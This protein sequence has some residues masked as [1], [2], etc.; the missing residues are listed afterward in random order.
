MTV[1]IDENRLDLVTT[2]LNQALETLR[3][4]AK[5]LLP[6]EFEPT[7]YLAKIKDAGRVARSE[8]I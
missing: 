3:P 1:R 4:L 8:N 5:L 7:T 2:A 6:K